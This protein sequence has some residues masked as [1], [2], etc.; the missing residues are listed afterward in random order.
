MRQRRKKGRKFSTRRYSR[1]GFWKEVTIRARNPFLNYATNLLKRD[2]KLSLGS[3]LELVSFFLFIDCTIRTTASHT[4]HSTETIVEWWHTFRSGWGAVFAREPQF[5]GTRLQPVQIDESYFSGR[6]KYSGGFLLCGYRLRSKQRAQ[7]EEG[8]YESDDEDSYHP[9]GLD[10][11]NWT[12]VLGIYL[13]RTQVRFVRVKNRKASTL[14][15]VIKKYVKVGSLIWTDEFSSYKSLSEHG[16]EYESVNHSEHYVEPT[17]GAHTQGIERS[18]R[19]AKHWH[20]SSRGNPTLLQSHLDECAYRRFRAPE[21][22]AGTSFQTFIR[23]LGNCN[24]MRQS[25]KSGCVSR[26]LSCIR[27]TME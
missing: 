24:R 25:H 6:R 8:V 4:K 21:K 22:E 1:K 18:W 15:M 5:H 23:D 27:E 20:R 14:L 3:I 12:W 13:S 7:N 26:H 16:Y 17:T 10:N 19:E 2:S 11:M 9:Y